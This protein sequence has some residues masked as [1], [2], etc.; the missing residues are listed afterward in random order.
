MGLG[1][2][3]TGMRCC[4]YCSIVAVVVD[5]LPIHHLHHCRRELHEQRSMS[6]KMMMMM[7]TW[8]GWSQDLSLSA[9]RR[10][11]QR[12]TLG[13]LHQSIQCRCSGEGGDADADDGQ[14]YQKPSSGNGC[15]LIFR[16]QTWMGEV[17]SSCDLQA[18][19]QAALL[20]CIQCVCISIVVLVGVNESL[21]MGNALSYG[22]LLTHSRSAARP[23]QWL[24]TT[25]GR[26]SE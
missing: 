12:A 9:P 20:R 2:S 13:D 21:E 4:C 6:K 15:R 17:G 16:G 14:P 10:Q 5:V 26:V 25:E 3:H 18:S 24:A 19:K 22:R 23:E 7:K 11:S 1:S 8:S